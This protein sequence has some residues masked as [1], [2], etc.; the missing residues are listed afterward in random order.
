M[1]IIAYSAYIPDVVVYA[2]GCP[3]PTIIDAL[4]K[5]A[6]AFFFSSGVYRT[7]VTPFDLTISTTT[8]AIDAKC[9]TGTEV[10]DIMEL[11]CVG[12]DVGVKSHEEFD[13]LDPEWPSK[14]GTYAQYFTMLDSKNAF[15]IIPIPSATVVNAFTMQISVCPTLTSTG[16]EQVHFELWK[17]Q[18]IDGALARIL[19][20]PK[21]PWTDMK[22]ANERHGRYSAGKAAARIQANK[23]NTRRDLT[24]QMRRWV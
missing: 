4:R 11:R 20:I 15:N 21:R 1:A 9:P 16:V 13:A 14:T 24:V 17:D 2:P 5:T 7:W 3:G 19:S 12:A 10:V 18:I 22:E 8:Y 23:G 6:A